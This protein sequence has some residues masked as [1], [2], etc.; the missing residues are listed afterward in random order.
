MDAAGVADVYEGRVTDASQ[1]SVAEATPVPDAVAAVSSV[2][3]KPVA[4]GGAV[5]AGAVSSTIVMVWTSVPVLPHASVEL[6]VRVM[7]RSG[8][9]GSG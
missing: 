6:H 1:L 5:T 3:S 2:H 7:V 8:Q 9:L 4:S